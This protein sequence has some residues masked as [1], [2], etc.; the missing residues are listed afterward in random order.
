[1]MMTMT[2]VILIAILMMIINSIIS[3]EHKCYFCGKT[4]NLEVHHIMSNSNRDKSTKYGLVV[5][6]CKECHRGTH[7]VHSDYKKMEELRKVA[8]ERFILNY[9]TLDWLSI[10]HRNYLTEEEI[11]NVRNKNRKT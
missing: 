10:F 1:M 8:Q 3:T 6:L 2:I 11:N 7:G 9:P 4:H 5:Y